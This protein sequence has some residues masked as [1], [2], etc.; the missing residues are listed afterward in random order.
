MLSRPA[1][2]WLLN[3]SL[4]VFVALLIVAAVSIRFYRTFPLVSKDYIM[5]RKD[6]GLTLLD[7]NHQ[8]FFAFGDSRPKTYQPLSAIPLHTRQAVIAAE[9]KEFYSHYGFSLRGLLRSAYLDLRERQLEYGGSTISQQL[10][11]SS[12]LKPDKSLKRKYQELLL[13]IKLERSY[14]KDDILE[15]YLNSAYFG[16]GAF[17]IEQA[18]KI[19]FSQSAR[20]LSV[21]ESALLAGLLPAPSRFSPLADPNQTGDVRRRYVLDQMLLAGFLNAQERAQAEAEPIAFNRNG[22]GLNAHA[23]HFALMVRDELFRRF[24]EESVMRSGFR[25]L[26]TLDLDWQ[27]Y[28]E[29]ALYNH[30]VS[31]RSQNATNGAAVMMDPRSG[32]ILALAGSYDWND[33]DNGRI[34]LATSPRQTGSAFKPIVYA[35]ALSSGAIT[36]S[37]ILYDTPTTFGGTYRPRDYDGKFRG[38]VPVREALANSLNV[39]A[40][41]VASL[42]GPDRVASLA[43][44]LGITTLSP[45]ADN[46][47]SI[48]LGTESI[49]L[50]QLTG[51]YAA[52]A[53]SGRFN[54]P[55]IISGVND[56]LGSTVYQYEPPNTPALDPGASF[57][58]SSIL[59]DNRARQ[60]IFGYSLSLPFSAAVKTGTTQDYRDAWTVGYTPDLAVGVWIGNNNNQ[61]MYRLAG[62]LGAAPLW[63]NLM[64]HFAAVRSDDLPFTA[65]ADI[66]MARVCRTGGLVSTGGYT[67]YYL[68]GTEPTRYC[69]PP[70]PSLSASPSVSSAPAPEPKQKPVSIAV[71]K[72]HPAAAADSDEAVQ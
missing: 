40:V 41:S 49:S 23:P 63:R 25:V 45:F 21:N 46:N 4:A 8:L 69:S 5:N 12:L 39:P 6:T 27:R 10:I 53:N 42:I 71:N 22:R 52:F 51:A 3:I 58:L 36:P 70:V 13:A 33:P 37:S 60:P 24:G 66:V 18:A 62:S 64:E 57:L 55:A 1:R 7:R 68:T 72:P 38:P 31:L 54:P 65:P 56:K 2:L 14:S 9:D 16:Q 47:L 17:G 48:A 11:K 59:A 35:S 67:E 34:N 28:L 19:Y 30:V 43:R 32:E 20:D 44:T 29:T 26:T 61:P 15:M 50:V